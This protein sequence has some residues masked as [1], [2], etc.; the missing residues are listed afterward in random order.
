[1]NKS[2]LSEQLNLHMMLLFTCTPCCKILASNGPEIAQTVNSSSGQRVRGS[3]Q[4]ELI[5]CDAAHCRD[6]ICQSVGALSPVNHEGLY[7]GWKRTSLHLLL[8]AHKSHETAKFLK[9][10]GMSLDTKF[11]TKHTNMKHNFLKKWL[12]SYHPR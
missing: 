9:I 6:T 7:Q 8:I 2:V 1:M 5:S 3:R 11:K 4:K 12:I 10:H